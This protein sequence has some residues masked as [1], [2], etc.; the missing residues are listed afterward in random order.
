MKASLH[1]SAPASGEVLA[2][3]NSED[4]TEYSDTDVQDL[5]GD[6]FSKMFLFITL[7]PTCNRAKIGIVVSF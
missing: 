5:R 1:D 7:M 2:D 3:D 6:W 4:K